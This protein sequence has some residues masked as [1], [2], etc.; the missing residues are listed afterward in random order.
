MN[1]FKTIALMFV[2]CLLSVPVM[3]ESN[4][5]TFGLGPK[6]AAAETICFTWPDGTKECFASEAEFTAAM[7]R[8]IPAETF[9]ID[10]RPRWTVD[11]GESN[12]T[13]HMAGWPH[14]KDVSGLSHAEALSI[15]DSDHDAIGPV[16]R[17]QIVANNSSRLVATPC[18][19]CPGGVSYSFYQQSQVVS[20]S[21]SGSS[22]SYLTTGQASSNAV[23]AGVNRSGN[24]R[25]T[26]VRTVVSRL[27]VGFQQNRADRTGLLS[28]LFG[29][30]SGLFGRSAFRSRYR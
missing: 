27:V 11:G 22:V 1:T 29:N 9:G 5:P 10:Y 3:A 30:R 26:P 18:P 20:G 28:R 16:S 13:N 19:S 15:H 17:S 6:A 14:G 7:A 25:A 4:D 8:G 23:P 12:I 21:Y 2:T 24:P